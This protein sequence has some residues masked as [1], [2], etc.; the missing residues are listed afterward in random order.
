M[1]GRAGFWASIDLCWLNSVRLSAGE[2]RSL[3][4][5]FSPEMCTSVS[6]LECPRRGSPPVDLIQPPAGSDCAG[7]EKASQPAVQAELQARYDTLFWH[8]LGWDLAIVL[9]TTAVGVA[10]AASLVRPLEGLQRARA[11]SEWRFDP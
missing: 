6:V 5:K 3:R 7:H 8:S 11:C 2:S 1:A 9:L 10:L 4:F